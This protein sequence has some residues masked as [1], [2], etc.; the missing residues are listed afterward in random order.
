MDLQI[1]RSGFNAEETDRESSVKYTE[2][3]LKVPSTYASCG[4]LC[5]YGAFREPGAHRADNVKVSQHEDCGGTTLS[6]RF[7]N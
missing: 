2:C 1:S 4:W 7:I 6:K 3:L 5:N